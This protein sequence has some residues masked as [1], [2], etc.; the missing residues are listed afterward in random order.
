MAKKTVSP[1]DMRKIR[2]V[3]EVRVRKIRDAVLAESRQLSPLG[4]SHK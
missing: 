1:A 2:P 3:N 4:D